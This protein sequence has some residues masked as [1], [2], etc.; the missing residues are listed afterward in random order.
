MKN[1]I[2]NNNETINSIQEAIKN[3]K[4]QNELYYLNRAL[5]EATKLHD[6]LMGVVSINKT[7]F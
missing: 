2:N 6:T 7:Y 3:C 4:N 5:D 1:Y